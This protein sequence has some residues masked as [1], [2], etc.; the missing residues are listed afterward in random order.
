ML[1]GAGVSFMKS[2]DRGGIKSML[3]S[4][5]ATIEEMTEFLGLLGNATEPRENEEWKALLAEKNVTHIWAGQTIYAGT[6][7]TM[8]APMKTEKDDAARADADQLV[9]KAQEMLGYDTARL[10]AEDTVAGVPA[11]L[12][13]LVSKKNM[14]L[15]KKLAD[16]YLG[17]L[18]EGDDALR[19]SAASAAAQIYGGAAGTA[20]EALVALTRG[21]VT[22]ALQGENSPGPFVHL[23]SVGSIVA[24]KCLE[25]KDAENLAA[26]A[27][28]MRRTAEA[29]PGLAGPSVEALKKLAGSPALKGLI[30]EAEA[31]DVMATLEAFGEAAVP[32]L[33]EMIKTASSTEA[34]RRAAKAIHA[35]GAKSEAVLLGELKADADA[36][37][38]RRILSVLDEFESNLTPA[39]KRLVH[40]PDGKV[41]Q[42]ML[43]LLERIDAAAICDPL[44]ETA[45][46]SDAAAA[47]AAI[48][49]L[50]GLACEAAVNGLCEVVVTAS[51]NGV[52]K[53]ACNALGEIASPESLGT[54]KEVIQAKKMMG[55]ATVYSSDVR[56]AAVWAL[57]AIPG[58]EA[59]TLL[60]QL[61]KDK[62]DNVKGAAFA[63]LD[64]RK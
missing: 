28:A 57:R 54:L 27:G 35:C 32:L 63:A 33:V 7:L 21:G 55:L 22:K 12:Q 61:T 42:E 60:D 15:F 10:V 6:T 52:K 39:L 11:I 16:K 34:A 17:A 40:H 44:L 53:T 37:V 2:M 49:V 30:E 14:D 26:V 31:D 13:A 8:D 24:A 58:D 59:G 43:P 1:G 47:G 41:L 46:G 3:V 48:Q 38:C 25:K 5:D 45:R 64:E 9:A 36:A 51:D 62:D 29:A 20:G 19:E 56:A 4:K 18:S 50:G 23:L